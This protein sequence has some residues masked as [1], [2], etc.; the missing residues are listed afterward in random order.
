M[1]DG[2]REEGKSLLMGRRELCELNADHHFLAHTHNHRSSKK[3]HSSLLL[4]LSCKKTIKIFPLVR[5]G[6]EISNISDMGQ[7]NWHLQGRVNHFIF[8]LNRSGSLEKFA[9][10]K[11]HQEYLISI[12]E[13]S[14]LKLHCFTF[15][16]LP[17]SRV[18]T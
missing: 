17:L 7:T 8:D 16:W 6:C 3:S 18:S 2:H 5:S 11:R 4:F 13:T 12:E 15:Y 1:V 9:F 10:E 14:C